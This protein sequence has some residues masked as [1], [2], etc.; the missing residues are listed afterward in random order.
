M[1]YYG[2]MVIKF[3][4]KKIFMVHTGAEPSEDFEQFFHKLEDLLEKY[5]IEEIIDLLDKIELLDNDIHEQR[6]NNDYCDAMIKYYETKKLGT[7]DM[8]EKQAKYIYKSRFFEYDRGYDAISDLFKRDYSRKCP[9]EF[10]C[11][12]DLD[13]LVN[14]SIGGS[15]T[16][17]EEKQSKNDESYDVSDIGFE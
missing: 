16:I 6:C 10:D 12:D 15:V 4:N 9:D 13:E 8:T 2:Y 1:G 11:H 17:N 7:T 3:K 5:S 14:N